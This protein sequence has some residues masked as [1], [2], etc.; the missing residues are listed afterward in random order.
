MPSNA[1]THI[2]DGPPPLVPTDIDDGP[3]PLL[4]VED[5]DEGGSDES[6]LVQW[7]RAQARRERWE[8]EVVLLREDF[9]RGL[10]YLHWRERVSPT[11]F[12]P[13]FR[14]THDL[15]RGEQWP[16]L[17]HQFSLAL[18][19]AGLCSAPPIISYDLTCTWATVRLPVFHRVAHS[20]TCKFQM[21]S[22]NAEFEDAEHTQP[23]TVR[24]ARPSFSRRASDGE[25][26]VRAK[27]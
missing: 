6:V 19:A 22:S 23:V 21:M 18:V 3:P 1:A 24:S 27:L 25:S 17:Y 2:D 5:F 4:P 10:Q 7:S 12:E 14:R 20:P 13:T 8:E 11:Q 9:R 15:Q 16:T 26:Q